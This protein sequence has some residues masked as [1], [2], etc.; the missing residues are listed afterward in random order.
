MEKEKA[1]A[2][3]GEMFGKDT[4]WAIDCFGTYMYRDD[5]GDTETK[6]I[7]PGNTK[8]YSY[9]WEVDH[10]R[11]KSDF[12]E[13]ADPDINNNYEIMYWGN[14]RTKADNYPH[15]QIDGSDYTV[16]RCEMC[17]SHG[18]KGYG[19]EDSDGKRIDWKGKNRQYF[20]HNK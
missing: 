12:G 3:W 17:S 20:I 15:F 18:L 13:K 10:L 9:G 16:V 4:K 6:R 8:K 1:L 19:I 14:N 11:P 2:L 5:Y 7:R